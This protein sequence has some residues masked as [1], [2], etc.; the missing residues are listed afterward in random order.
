MWQDAVA[1]TVVALTVVL[2]T[3]RMLL[4]IPHA[5]GGACGDC[6][7]CAGEPGTVVSADTLRVF[8][9]PGGRS[10]PT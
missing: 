7:G 6:R 3:R 10:R 4:S 1:L 8:S 2:T 5:R 9:P